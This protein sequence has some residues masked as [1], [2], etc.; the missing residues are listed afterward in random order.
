M[1]NFDL[2]CCYII[3]LMREAV[4]YIKLKDKKVRC[5]A[6]DHSCLIDEN[7]VGVCGVRQNIN[8]NLQLLVYGRAISVNV[9]PV[10]KK[11]L[12][13]FLPGEST[14]SFGTLG[15]NF[16]C[17]NCHNYD[18]SQMFEVKGKID[19]YRDFMWGEEYPPEKIVQGAI[20]N[21]CSSVAY[22]YNEPTVFSEYAL[23]TMKLARGKG[24]KNIWVS[25][26]FMSNETI[27]LILPYIDAINVDIKS[28][29]DNFYRRNCGARLQPVLDNCKRFVKE[30]V[31]LEVTTL[32]VPTLSDNERMLKNLAEFVKK[33]LGD[34]V[35]WHVSAF[36]GSISWK[37][38]DLPSTSQKVVRDV[39]DIGKKAG[40][41]FVYAGNM[42][43]SKLESTFCPKCRAVLIERYGYRVGIKNLK[44]GT[45][46]KC[47]EK[48]QGIWN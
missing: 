42:R 3:Y 47:K 31:W 30:G 29:D 33:E 28:F 32:V 5:I 8:G 38:K 39:Y 22:T 4:L 24:L 48:I 44:G 14:F 9:D 11:P 2:V 25:N 46:G 13:H 35:P 27:D 19:K 17:A 40:L 43:D 10:E 37:L 23:D 16:R 36:L 18:I 41:K 20:A 26:G 45:C 21:N 34:F 6:C 15:C 7:K 12:F 1:H